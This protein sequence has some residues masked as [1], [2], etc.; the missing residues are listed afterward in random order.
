MIIDKLQ[1]RPQTL[2]QMKAELEGLLSDRNP[3]NTERENQI[4]RLCFLM[5]YQEFLQA[6][7][8]DASMGVHQNMKRN[9]LKYLPHAEAFKLQDCDTVPLKKYTLSCFQLRS[10]LLRE[11]F[12]LLRQY[13]DAFENIPPN[14]KTITLDN[15][16]TTLQKATAEKYRSFLSR[17]FAPFYDHRKYALE[18][19]NNGQHWQLV[20]SP[21][22]T[23][24]DEIQAGTAEAATHTTADAPTVVPAHRDTETPKRTVHTVGIGSEARLLGERIETIQTSFGAV[25][26]VSCRGLGKN[27]PNEDIGMTVEFER[28][29][30]HVVWLIAIDG[31]GGEQSG[32]AAA[33]IISEELEKDSSG[34]P[35]NPLNNAMQRMQDEINLENGKNAGAAISITEIKQNDEGEK[36]VRFFWLGDTQ[37][38]VIKEKT[39]RIHLSQTDRAIYY[40]NGEWKANEKNIGADERH[41]HPVKNILTRA[42]ST[43]SR[44]KIKPPYFIQTILIEAGDIV[45]TLSDGILDNF[46]PEEIEL[47]IKG[48]KNESEI[49]QTLSGA[50]EQRLNKKTEMNGQLGELGAFITDTSLNNLSDIIEKLRTSTGGRIDPPTILETLWK[51]LP[52][53]QK[54]EATF[55]DALAQR[56]QRVKE[57]NAPEWIKNTKHKNTRNQYLGRFIL[58][59]YPDGF[60][61]TPKEDNATA[62]VH[63]VS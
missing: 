9:P 54:N 35:I 52:D 41:Y 3:L 23:E 62:V 42:C 45:L 25:A 30:R 22:P 11:G 56:I 13:I 19:R 61:C 2:E 57:G 36:Q 44:R 16:P 33:K 47:L 17:F 4:W 49:I 59:C 8:F 39:K 1:Q 29:G 12:G 34:Y 50:L 48:K 14:G 18:I 24:V 5:V 6:E 20:L 53:A 7:N 55:L 26:I 27:G 63:I 32:A 58:G 43:K 21:I 60:L 40:R 28:E 38:I 51:A 46:T 37:S 10:H 31:M 15:F